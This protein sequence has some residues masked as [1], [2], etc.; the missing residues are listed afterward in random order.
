VVY[1]IEV[2]V[3]NEPIVNIPLAFSGAIPLR[4]G[5]N[6]SGYSSDDR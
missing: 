1:A 6:M 5:R 2:L 4:D 3:Q